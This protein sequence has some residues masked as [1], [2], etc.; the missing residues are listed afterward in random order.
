MIANSTSSTID[1]I[2]TMTIAALDDTC[3]ITA[4][5]IPIGCK[6]YQ[7]LPS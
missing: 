2:H 5:E 4:Q 1:E 7:L 6:H 3:P